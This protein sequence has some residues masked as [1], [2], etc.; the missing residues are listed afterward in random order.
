MVMKKNIVHSYYRKIIDKH[1]ILVQVNPETLQGVELI[2]H[3]DGKVE[4]TKLKYDEDIYE[5]LKVDEFKE[6]SALEFNLYLKGIT[7]AD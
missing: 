7:G 3:P 2:I 1:K 4:K 6:S 5:D